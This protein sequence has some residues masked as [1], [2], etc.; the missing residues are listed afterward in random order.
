MGREPNGKKRKKSG[1]N[2]AKKHARGT[3]FLWG[4]KFGVL[5]PKVFDVLLRWGPTRRQFCRRGGSARGRIWDRLLTGHSFIGKENAEREPPQKKMK[6][7]KHD[8]TPRA[9]DRRLRPRPI[10]RNQ[11]GASSWGPASSFQAPETR[12]QRNCVGVERGEGT[13]RREFFVFA[14]AA[15][16]QLHIT[17]HAAHPGCTVSS[18]STS[19]AAAPRARATS[20]AD[21][22]DAG[23]AAQH[24][25]MMVLIDGAR[26]TGS[27]R[28]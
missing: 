1:A 18:S 10:K 4:E 9:A 5:H 23:S 6:K 27:G 12:R 3:D 17:T 19:G 2:S 15:L 8:E 20:A 11:G 16:S 28:R 21:G 22:R 13:P 7:K 24:A 25:S 14:A 26:P